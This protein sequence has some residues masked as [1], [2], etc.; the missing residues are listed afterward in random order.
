MVKKLHCF[1]KE[2]RMRGGNR[3][4]Y[5]N[6]KPEKIS[7]TSGTQKKR[8]KVRKSGKPKHGLKRVDHGDVLGPYTH[9]V[10]PSGGD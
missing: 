5:G 6:S 4:L 8:K 7:K 2:I 9:F 3:K 10:I 1:F